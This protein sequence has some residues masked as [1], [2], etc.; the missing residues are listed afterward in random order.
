[1]PD[2]PESRA[3]FGGQSGRKGTQSGYPMARIGALMVL[4]SHLLAGVWFGPYGGTN[5]LEHAKE[6]GRPF[7]TTRSPSTTEG[8][9]RR[10]R[11]AA[12]SPLGRTAT[13]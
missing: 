1:V 2:T 11:R 4:R 10:R 6:Q 3:H 7:R 9:L 8:S 12:S 13:G 5:E